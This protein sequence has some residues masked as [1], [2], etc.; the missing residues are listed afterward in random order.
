MKKTRV[1]SCSLLVRMRVSECTYPVNVTRE[2]VIY[3]SYLRS[4]EFDNTDAQFLQLFEHPR[5]VCVLHKLNERSGE[6]LL[7]L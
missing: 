7:T 5:Q 2:F 6:V 1:M 3:V 4:A